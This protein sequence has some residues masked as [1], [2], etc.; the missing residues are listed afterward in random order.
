MHTRTHTWIKINAVKP[1][2]QCNVVTL[3]PGPDLSLVPS[4]VIYKMELTIF[5]ATGLLLGIK[6]D[7]NHMRLSRVPVSE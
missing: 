7:S 1:E 5:N 3:E 6:S 4:F 2:N